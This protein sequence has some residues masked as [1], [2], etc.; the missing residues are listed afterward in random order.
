MNCG[1]P[2]AR[3][4]FA[5]WSAAARSQIPGSSRNAEFLAAAPLYGVRRL[6]AAFPRFHL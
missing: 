1:C 6:D 3:A 4:K 2:E 5:I